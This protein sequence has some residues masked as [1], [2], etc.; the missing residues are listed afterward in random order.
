MGW[1]ESFSPLEFAAEE[2][3]CTIQ[4]L[5]KL[6]IKGKLS[7]YALGDWF[8]NEMKTPDQRWSVD[9]PLLLND[10]KQINT[11]ANG[12]SVQLRI[13]ADGRFISHRDCVDNDWLDGVTV[14]EINLFCLDA[15]IEKL[16]AN[17][18]SDT[19]ST[20]QPKVEPALSDNADIKVDT[21]KQGTR[22][23]QIEL[24]CTTAKNLKYEDLLNIPEGGRVEIKAKCLER[25]I[26]M[27][28][29]SFKRA[30]TEAGKRNLIRMKDKEK[31]L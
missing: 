16:I 5:L 15:D 10:P 14:K 30:W 21:P 13:D 23:R 20:L 26:N 19:E 29:S 6:G 11:L 22:D 24:I 3:G 7:I 31:Y 25:P 2:V 12:G 1:P 27:T 9:S 28:D 4:R 17:T 18:I 8:W